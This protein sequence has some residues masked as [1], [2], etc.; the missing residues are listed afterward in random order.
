MT[1]NK[2]NNGINVPSAELA[3]RLIQEAYELLPEVISATKESDE[4]AI[5]QKVDWANRHR[6]YV[7]L[8]AAQD[9]AN[10]PPNTLVA[11]W[12]LAELKATL[13][14]VRRW[15][16]NPLWKDIEP[17]LKNPTHFNHTILKLHVAEHLQKGGH[18]VSIV[19]RGPESSPDLMF[20]A[21]G[22]AQDLVLVECY[23]P[24]ALSGQP[25]TVSAKETENIVKKAMQKAKEQL[26][27][28]KPGLLAL[29]GYNQP[30]ANLDALEQAAQA[31]LSKTQRLNFCGIALTILG[32]LYRQDRTERSFTPIFSL[33]FIH[34]P[35]YFGRVDIESTEPSDHPQRI[36][37]K[38]TDVSTD[39]LVPQSAYTET[40]SSPIAH[41]LV[42]SKKETS[43]SAQ[44]HKLK[45]IKT[46]KKLSRSVV[47]GVGSKV[48]PFFVGKGNIDFVC[49]TCEE[50]LATHIW[51]LSISNLVLECPKC[52]A[53]NEFPTQPAGDY[54]TVKMLRGD[55]NFSDSVKLKPGKRLVGEKTTSFH[56]F[57]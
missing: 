4:K 39:S 8:Q 20:T 35:S 26:D 45:V 14:I 42:E 46:P 11:P 3:R 34:N 54:P 29:G 32:V 21:I 51:V 5:R 19:P 28:L 7:L 16:A 1:S 40:V 55:Y 48:P 25:R 41:N 17:S 53:Y 12:F 56:L 36:K 24:R 13:E 30:T 10:S 49:G 57:C 43:I 31:R 50:A 37:D 27:P 15:R 2:S 47:H 52:G 38:L 23:Q 22:G 33:R 44:V 6:L 9:T 18:R